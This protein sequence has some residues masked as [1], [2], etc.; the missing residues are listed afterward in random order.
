VKKKLGE[1][2]RGG[3]LPG[4]LESSGRDRGGNVLWEHRVAWLKVKTFRCA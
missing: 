3:F 2:E 4:R 1:G